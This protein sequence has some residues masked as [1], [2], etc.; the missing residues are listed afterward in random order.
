M[1]KKEREEHEDE[2]LCSFSLIC[3]IDLI[4]RPS[5][6]PRPNEFLR[7]MTLRISI[8]DKRLR[9]RDVTAANRPIRRVSTDYLPS[10]P[11]RPQSIKIC[12]L[13]YTSIRN[14]T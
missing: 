9:G 1:E 12:S 2:R 14:I 10:K 11:L 4:D 3:L 8:I 5:F 7:A 13:V 6:D